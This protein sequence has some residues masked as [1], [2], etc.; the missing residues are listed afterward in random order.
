MKGDFSRLSFK[1]RNHFSRVL[2]QQGRVALDADQNEQSAILL[3]YMRMLARDLIGCGGAG[4]GFALSVDNSAPPSLLISKGHYYVDGILVENDD[5]CDYANQPDY[6]P[7]G[8]DALRKQLKKPDAQTFPWWIYLDVWERH[9]TF[10]ENSSIR[11]SALDGPDTCTRAQVVWQ[12][13]ALSVPAA[14]DTLKKRQQVI[15]KRRDQ[16][17]NDPVRQAELAAEYDR[18]GKEIDSL[19]RA[20]AQADNCAAPLDTLDPHG[21]G[22]MAARLDPGQQIKTPCLIAPDAQYRGA[23]NQLYRI[24]IHDGGEP[25]TATF[26]W[27]RENGSVASALIE[28]DGNDLVVANT[29]GFAAGNWVE[30]SYD[31]LDLLGTPGMLVKLARVD[32]DRLSIDSASLEG[33]SLWLAQDLATQNPK[34]RRWEQTQHDKITLQLGAVPIDT[35]QPTWIDLEDGIQV[36]FAADG[37]YR[38]G[39]YWLMPARVSNG[40]IDWPPAIDG[41]TTTLFKP[42]FGTEH[43]YAPLGFLAWS[44]ANGK[45]EIATACHCAITPLCDCSRDERR[46]LVDRVAPNAVAAPAA[47]TAKKKA[48]VAGRSGRKKG[49]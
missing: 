18:L 2:W 47:R 46:G 23:E 34:V 49:R 28:T 38:S 45:F 13:K 43:H 19:S 29:R 16:A 37:E 5:G 21:S 32:G 1:A 30:L 9:I 36:Q 4:P 22:R 11:E 39:D 27:S 10:I 14:V 24:E 12:V 25:G 15:G 35:S 26:K 41:T 33:R 6:K 20:P 31:S 40:Q 48:G 7:D 17:A 8:D 3:H 42:P 44:A